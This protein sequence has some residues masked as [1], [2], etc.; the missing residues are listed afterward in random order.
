MPLPNLVPA[1]AAKF[2]LHPLISHKAS[3]KHRRLPYRVCYV[4]HPDA[5]LFRIIPSESLRRYRL[6]LPQSDHGDSMKAKLI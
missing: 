6:A 4:V 1:N 2:L 3:H 5:V